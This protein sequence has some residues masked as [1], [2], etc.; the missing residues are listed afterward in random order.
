MKRNIRLSVCYFIIGCMFVSCDLETERAGRVEG[1]WH[2]EQVDS[3]QTNG[4]CDL[5]GQRLFW[6]FERRLMSLSDADWQHLEYLLRFNDTGDSLFLSDPYES[7]REKGDIAISDAAV[8][9]PYGI[10]SLNDHFKI[11]LLSGQKML[12]SNTRWRLRFR[13]F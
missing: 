3:L 13:K 6:S 5:S 11:E 2:L 8:L 9:A 12:L 10:H 1:M 7:N 4:V